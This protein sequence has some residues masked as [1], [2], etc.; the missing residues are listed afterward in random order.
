MT[1]DLLKLFTNKMQKG[2]KK[3]HKKGFEEY[4]TLS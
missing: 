2:T 4:K 3:G 1:D